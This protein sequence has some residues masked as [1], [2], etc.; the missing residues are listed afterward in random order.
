[1]AGKSLFIAD[2]S[3][4]ELVEQVKNENGFKSL[5]DTVEKGMLLLQQQ[6]RNEPSIDEKIAAIQKRF[7]TKVRK[8]NPHWNEEDKK[9]FF[10][11]LSGGI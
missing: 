3:V 8:N 4:R 10:D 9:A 11:D 6:K 7:R 2:P 5:R 1:M